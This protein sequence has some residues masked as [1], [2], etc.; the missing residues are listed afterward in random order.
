M[1]EILER[2]IYEIL[3]DTTQASNALRQFEEDLLRV[4]QLVSSMSARG[5]T[6]LWGGQV[7]RIPADALTD[8]DRYIRRLND[9][10]RAQSQVAR[11]QGNLLPSTAGPANQ[12]PIAY[13]ESPELRR[14]R[15]L[16]ADAPAWLDQYGHYGQVAGVQ[17][18]PIQLPPSSVIGTA[19]EIERQAKAVQELDDKLKGL[20]ETRRQLGGDP[21][22]ASA[23]LGIPAAVG[24]SAPQITR[25]STLLGSGMI[26]LGTPY[27]PPGGGA[28]P[29]SGGG[30]GWPP[31]Q[32]PV[33]TVPNTGGAGGGGWSG[34]MPG[35][36]SAGFPTGLPPVAGGAG[37]GGGG[38]PGTPA[39]W[40][41]YA[42][43]GPGGLPGGGG[44]GGGGA[45]S[46]IAGQF[47]RSLLV[48]GLLWEA[49]NRLT[50][51]T[52]QWARNNLQADLTLRQI[53]FTARGTGSSLRDLAAT[54]REVLLTSA[55]YGSAPEDSLPT[56]LYAARTT[57]DP[58]EQ[59]AL[60]RGAAQLSQ[61]SG[62]PQEQSAQQLYQ[63]S[64]TF[65]E[66]LSNVGQIVDAAAEAFRSSNVDVAEYLDTLQRVAPLF[67]E[68]GYSINETAGYVSAL[69]QVTGESPSKIESMLESVAGLRD[70][71]GNLKDLRDLQ[72]PTRDTKVDALPAPQQIEEV[73]KAWGRLNE[74]Q[75][76]TAVIALLG[77]RYLQEGLDLFNN[78]DQIESS[79]T[80]FNQAYGAGN[81][82]VDTRN[83]SLLQQLQ[84]LGGL[85]Q[86]SFTDSFVIERMFKEG[87]P[88]QYVQNRSGE[89][90]AAFAGAMGWGK[91]PEPESV[92]QPG[93]PGFI[94]HV[95][96]PGARGRVQPNRFFT[97]SGGNIGAGIP[98]PSLDVS[99]TSWEQ[100][101][102]H[103]RTAEGLAKQYKQ[104]LDAAG[105]PT[106]ELEDGWREASIAV[107]TTD[108]GIKVVTGSAAQFLSQARQISQTMKEWRAPN[109]EL[110]DMSEGDLRKNIQIANQLASQYVNSIRSS[111][112][113]LSAQNQ[114]LQ[115]TQQQ[116]AQTVQMVRLAGGAIV[117]L[118]GPTAA[119]LNLA[120]GV[121]NAWS[122]AMQAMNA[123]S[124]I[125][126]QTVTNLNAQNAAQLQQYLIYY[127]NFLRQMGVMQTAQ[128]YLL[129]GQNGYTGQFVTSAQALQLALAL[130]GEQVDY[131]QAATM[132]NVEALQE[133]TE[134]QK[135]TLRGSFNVPTEFGYRPPT[136]WNYYD[137]GGTQ[138]GPV[139]YPWLFPKDNGGGGGGL[140]NVDKFNM[141]PHLGTVPTGP[142][143][144]LP[145]TFGSKP[146]VD[147]ITQLQLE[148]MK[149]SELQNQIEA[150]TAMTNEI[151]SGEPKSLTAGGAAGPAKGILP[152][153]QSIV[154]QYAKAFRDLIPAQMTGGLGAGSGAV[155]QM[156][157]AANALTGMIDPLRGL[158]AMSQ[159]FGARPDYYGKFGLAGH[160]GTDYAAPEGTPVYAA[161]PGTIT[162]V[163]YGEQYGN[164]VWQKLADGA[165]ILYAHLKDLPN[166]KVGQQVTTDTQI[167][168]VGSTGN[169]T[170]PHLHF[171]YR[172]PGA[173]T[174]D[175]FKGW[176]DPAE[177]L[178]NATLNV[179]GVE[180]V[181]QHTSATAVSVQQIATQQPQQFT[182][183]LQQLGGSNALLT[184]IL[185][186]INRT[187]SL[188]ARLPTEP[189]VLEMRA[190]GSVG[191]AQNV[192]D[193]SAGSS[194]FSGVSGA[195]P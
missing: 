27:A 149:Q 40:G 3:A 87:G 21:T 190:G 100:L 41:F 89:A 138:M 35:F 111:N 157:N 159:A 59:V 180:Q 145:T 156:Q 109:L 130:L 38:A 143:A 74:A 66:P 98:I 115:Q 154:D 101:Q 95:W 28:I 187:N 46:S 67:T 170:G 140:S 129:F 191:P 171:G 113:P 176:Q 51:V 189:V 61:F 136:P 150:N 124:Q 158:G 91:Q 185:S 60:T 22:A 165:E 14:M 24:S 69:N 181:Q 108:Q 68:A 26:P 31:Y 103:I 153:A 107:R 168:E 195:V 127:E 16:R 76:E 81:E 82:L 73:A 58:R 137:Q 17:N 184:G 175:P 83:A 144:L 186:A 64:K 36:G 54:Q 4:D 84:I 39:P 12:S 172:P 8:V 166:L 174:S 6:A 62:L 141:Q 70:R 188:L 53:E 7:F 55:Q 148:A 23:T 93:Q 118:Q 135:D 71:T 139:N 88:M 97:E 20:L 65:N 167:G 183:M 173:D 2:R 160:E 32:G 11:N 30:G 120:Q 33:Y 114:I 72:I 18:Q 133:N 194:P 43:G 152:A 99:E 112:L 164:Q 179:T 85:M 77:R 48:Y 119:F 147:P 128:Q 161:A 142:A 13:E 126:V 10:E 37:G 122:R 106:K 151:L 5:Q 56:S 94:G 182:S 102:E 25:P 9:L 75:R 134:V 52:E 110:S 105:V 49:V 44:G 92:P 123:A 193:Q 177:A 45:M 155:Q 78:F 50:Q 117:T 86:A 104:A 80:K 162:K 42:G 57:R 163:A 34:G 125:S 29:P 79:V 132:D 146:P 178:K 121:S 169:S 116:W 192:V 47:M 63:I 131:Q 96:D 19:A 90:G 1:D 15:M